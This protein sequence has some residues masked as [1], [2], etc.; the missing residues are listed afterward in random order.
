MQKV[1][2]QWKWFV[3]MLCALALC[4]GTAFPVSAFADDSIGAGSGIGVDESII[5]ANSDGSEEYALTSGVNIIKEGKENTVF[6]IDTD[7]A[8]MISGQDAAE[9]SPVVFTNCTFNLSGPTV[10]ISGNQDGISYNN[11]EVITKLWIGGNVRFE[12][13]TFVTDS[14]GSKSTSAGFDACIYFVSGNIALNNCSLTADGY[15]GQFL[16]LYGKSGAVQFIN[17]KISAANNHNGWC[18]AMYGGS[19]LKLDHSTMSATGAS[20]DSGNINIFY[21]GDNLTGYDAIFFK[22]S[23]IDFSDNKAGGFAINNVN[24]LVDNSSITVSNNLGNACNSGFWIVNSSSIIMNGNRGGHALSC[25]GFDMTNSRLEVLH[26]GYAGVYIKSK[27]SSLTN[28]S[29]DLRCNGEKM[30]SYTAGDLW[31]NGYTLTVDGGTSASRPGYAWLGAV[32]RKGSVTTTSGS[33]VAYDLNTNAADNLKSN[34]TPVL[35]NASI[36]LNDEMHTLLLNP[37]METVYARGNAETSANNNDADLFADDR[38]T[39]PADILGADTAKIGEVSTAQLSHHNYDWSQPAKKDVSATETTYGARAY[40]CT[41]VCSAYTSNTSS[42]PNSFDCEGT[43]VYAPLVGIEFEANLPAGVDA[44]AVSGIPKTVSTYEYGQTYDEPAAPSIQSSADDDYYYV[45]EGWCTDSACSDGN[46]FDFTTP[47]TKNWT[48]LYAKWTKQ[49]IA[50]VQ[51]AD[52]TIYM[53][54]EHGYSG[55]ADET[56]EIQSNNSLPEPG[57]YITLPSEI[58]TVL[59]EAG[60]VT[61]G[62]PANLSDLITIRTVGETS[63]TWT[64]APYGNTFSAAYNKYIYAITPANDETPS[65]RLNFTDENGTTYDSDNFDPSDIHSLSQHYKMNVYAGLVDLRQVIIQID[66]PVS[67]EETKTYYCT[68][69][70]APGNLNIRY[71]TGDQDSVV[72][73]SFTSVEE[74]SKKDNPNKT[75]LDKA[76]VIRDEDT[77]FFINDSDVDVTEG[78]KFADVS[79]LFDDIVTDGNTEGASDYYSLLTDKAVA[80]AAEGMQDVKYE[81]KYLDLVD[82][83]NGNVWLTPSE[84][85]T[86]YWP[87]PDGTDANT[88]FKLVH[89][90]DLDREMDLEDVAAEIESAEIETLTVTTDAYG[91]S[92]QTDSFSPYV[93]LWDNSQSTTVVGTPTPDDHPDIAEAIANGTWGQPTPTPAPA[94]IPQTSDDM[95]ITLLIGAAGIAAAGIVVLV[96]LRKRKRNQ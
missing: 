37:F 1:R 78:E 53:G 74:A 85:V 64:L 41:D 36:A 76:Y 27:D 26:N 31:L 66:I 62:T 40:A 60:L 42:H 71:V 55:V 6:N 10:K 87:Y 81:A 44:N 29:V 65:F 12:N 11:G 82:A 50:V 80:E 3:C 16:G 73:S 13:C 35:T 33:V 28:C 38:V 20:T 57:Y 5:G 43:Y 70:T 47:L 14:S 45:F 21:S 46:K 8:V 96:I 72:T 32:G 95:P 7:K 89:F 17:S 91:I 75:A 59:E 61:E 19:V 93:L 39:A 56:G 63:Y 83:N 58:N 54:G 18:Y 90:K 94:V 2:S 92:F 22:D 49:Y 88:T 30:L 69:T 24:I 15:N 77:K 9:D 23:V 34:T 84:K 52:M 25:I 68:M 48:T 79:L 4:I 86:I 67:E 51:P